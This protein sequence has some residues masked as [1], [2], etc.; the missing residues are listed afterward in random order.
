MHM[1]GLLVQKCASCGPVWN[2]RPFLQTDRYRNMVRTETQVL[3]IFQEHRSVKGIA[4]LAGTFNNSLENRPDNGRRGGDHTEDVAAADLVSQRL[5]EVAS[6]RL[7]LA[8]QPRVLDGDHSLI[9]KG[10]KQLHVMSRA[11]TGLYPCHIDK[12]D[13]RPVAQ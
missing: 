3:T 13:W 7:H 8:E 6:F 11:H 1:H 2:D 4:K 5:R 9:G 10:L 12:T